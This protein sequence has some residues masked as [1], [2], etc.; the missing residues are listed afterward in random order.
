M[1]NDAPDKFERAVHMSSI[2]VD[3]GMHCV[4]C[5]FSQDG[6]GNGYLYGEVGDAVEIGRKDCHGTSQSYPTLRTTN[7]A[8]PPGGATSRS[9]AIPTASAAS[10]GSATSS[11][12]V[13][14]SMRAWN[15][16]CRWSRTRSRRV[17]RATIPR[18]RAPSS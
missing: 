15:G 1:P 11:S 12:S 13:P 3:V 10:S 14:S 7:P 9:S 17:T 6:H 2:H 5:H 18:P 8:A 16:R 4:D